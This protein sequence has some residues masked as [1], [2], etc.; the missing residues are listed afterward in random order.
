MLNIILRNKSRNF[1][2]EI[3]KEVKKGNFNFKGKDEIPL[4]GM[5]DKSRAFLMFNSYLMDI[6]EF[7]SSPL[8][9]LFYSYLVNA[10]KVEALRKEVDIEDVEIKYDAEDAGNFVGITS[11]SYHTISKYFKQLQEMGLIVYHR[12]RRGYY[13]R[14]IRDLR[15]SI[16]REWIE[17]FIKNENYLS[18][19]DLNCLSEIFPNLKVQ[20][21][22]G[23]V[24]NNEYMD[25]GN[26]GSIDGI[27]TDIDGRQGPLRVEEK[28]EE[29]KEEIVEKKESKKRGR[30]KKEEKAKEDRVGIF[31]KI[32]KELEPQVQE[33]AEKQ[34]EE[35]P[36]KQVQKEPDK[37]KEN[38]PNSEENK[39]NP[40]ASMSLEELRIIN[41]MKMK[42]RMNGV[43]SEVLKQEFYSEGFYPN[44]L[45]EEKEEEENE[46]IDINDI[47]EEEKE[48]REE[49]KEVKKEEIKHE[50]PTNVENKKSDFAEKRENNNEL[51]DITDNT[52]SD[53]DDMDW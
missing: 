39:P 28:E 24:R 11:T 6:A 53:I 22:Y 36:D 34:T 33:K 21:L 50:S 40:K 30:P 17:V 42:Q 32:K 27:D 13:F 38:K 10:A 15:N 51:T 49:V 16:N 18:P 43:S 1:I 14:C 31:N 9:G 37:E 7:Y 45:D 48:E 25:N 47:N 26:S 19:T 41:E 3:L 44:G 8:L 4:D 12:D 23:G 5:K 35:E 29:I 20:E 52:L 46:L 2:R